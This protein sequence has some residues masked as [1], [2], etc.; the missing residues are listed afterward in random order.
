MEASR[1]FQADKHDK[2]YESLVPR[3][4]TGKKGTRKGRGLRARVKICRAITSEKH[5]S[6]HE[7]FNRKTKSV[8]INAVAALSE[9]VVA[10]KNTDVA[11]G[12]AV[13]AEEKLV[14]KEHVWFIFEFLDI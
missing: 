1:A 3:S 14:L 12:K 4:L 7:I 8:K 9:V 2:G 10:I 6:G 13:V 5:P 11:A